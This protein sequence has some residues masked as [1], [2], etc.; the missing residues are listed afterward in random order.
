LIELNVVESCRNIIKTAAVQQSYRDHQYPVVHGWVF[1]L[2]DGLIKDLKI[3]FEGVL[4]DVKKIYSLS[5][6]LNRK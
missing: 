5:S 3:D 6:D 2:R 1:D 4:E